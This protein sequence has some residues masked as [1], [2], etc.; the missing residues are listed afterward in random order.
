MSL[1]YEQDKYK[2]FWSERVENAIWRDGGYSIEACILDIK[3][4]AE[5]GAFHIARAVKVKP[6]IDIDSL[7]DDVCNKISR[8]TGVTPASISENISKMSDYDKMT[9]KMQLESV[10][11]EGLKDRGMLDIYE[12]GSPALTYELKE[13]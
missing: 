2:W 13:E 4:N 7:L 10:L 11:Y 12:V 5:P 1:L 8:T 6:I 9:L 3:R